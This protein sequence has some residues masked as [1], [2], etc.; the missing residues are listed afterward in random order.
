MFKRI[1]IVGMGLMGGSLAAA[2]RKQ[3]PHAR[4]IGISRNPKA[5]SFARK[6]KWINEGTRELSEGVQAAD[7]IVLCVPVDQIASYLKQIDAAALPGTLVT[8]VGS[9]KGPIVRWAHSRRFKHIRFIS[10]H[11]MAG[12]HRRGIEAASP[13]LYRNS[14]TLVIPQDKKNHADF[15][16]VKQFWTRLGS[17]VVSLSADLHDQAV[18]EISHLPHALAVSLMRAV[19]ASSLP[20]AASGFRDTTRV[21][22]GDASVWLPIFFSNRKSVLSALKKFERALKEFR[23]ALQAK[24]PS[25]LKKIL[26]DAAKKRAQI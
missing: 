7:F 23:A 25:R 14:L 22:Q 16:K 26:C 13:V 8:D 4:V 11:P 2:C 6:K 24:H 12:S 21:S 5:L 10:S 3:F 9:V 17:K 18:G 20:F 1:A 19:S 15:L